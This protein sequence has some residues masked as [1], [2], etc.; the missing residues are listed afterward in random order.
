MSTIRTAPSM[1]A[2]G[3]ALAARQ[4][5]AADNRRGDHVE[6]VAGRVGARRR[7]VE[8]GAHERGEP[9]VS[10]E[11]TNTPIFTRPIGSPENRLAS[12][13]PPTAKTWR[14]ITVCV[15]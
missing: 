1:R 12:A 14:P 4:A 11:S 3:A 9:A 8:T 5:R 7:A 10:P 6:L 15:R 2:D 13:F